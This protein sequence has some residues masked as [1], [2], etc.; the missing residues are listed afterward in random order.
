M[1]G[2]PLPAKGDHLWQACLVLGTIHGNRIALDSLGTTYG[3]QFD[4]AHGSACMH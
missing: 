4:K 3:M 2:K 1:L